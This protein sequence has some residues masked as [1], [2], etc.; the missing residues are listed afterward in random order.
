[1]V[2]PCGLMGRACMGHVVV[3]VGKGGGGYTRKC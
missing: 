1:M 3:A 2:T